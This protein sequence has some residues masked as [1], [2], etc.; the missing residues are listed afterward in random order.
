M[1]QREREILELPAKGYTN[2]EIASR[3]NANLETVRVHVRHIYEK[4]HVH[5]RTEAAA[6]YLGSGE[7]GARQAVAGR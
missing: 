3:L 6:R 7:R 4:L 5:S 2:K 1:T